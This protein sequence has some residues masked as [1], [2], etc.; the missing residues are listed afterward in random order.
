[1]KEMLYYYLREFTIIDLKILN[2][3]ESIPFF[4]AVLNLPQMCTR[5]SVLALKNF[6]AENI[7]WSLTFHFCLKH[8]EMT[9]EQDADFTSTHESTWCT[10]NSLF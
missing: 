6:L 3:S 8:L 9:A 1:M 10:L 7:S 5:V 2:I 4:L